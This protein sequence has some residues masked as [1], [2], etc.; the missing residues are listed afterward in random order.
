MYQASSSYYNRT[1][2]ANAYLVKEIM[3]ATPQKLLIKIYDFAIT[4]C[5]KHDMERTN[6]AIQELINSLKFDDVTKEISTG[7]LKLYLYCQ[8]EMRKKNYEMVNKILTE[9]RD[10]WLK[11]FNM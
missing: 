2:Q 5:Q 11:A 7:F 10:A 9:L 8:E 1:N 3:E 4:N 6:R